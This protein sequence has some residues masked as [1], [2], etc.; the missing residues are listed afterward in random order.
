MWDWIIFPIITVA[1]LIALYFQLK[2]LQKLATE[3][4]REAKSYGKNVI[5]GIVAGVVVV[6]LDKSITIVFKN[7]PTIDYTSFLTTIVSGTAAFIVLLFEAGLILLLVIWI[8]NRGL[9]GL[10]KKKK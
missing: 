1:I 4:K 8:I 2:K 6:I 5:A 7:P 3:G 10:V 9:G